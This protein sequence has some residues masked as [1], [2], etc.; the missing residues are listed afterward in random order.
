MTH[1]V[2]SRFDWTSAHF[3]YPEQTRFYH[4]LINGPRFIKLFRPNPTL[5]SDGTWKP[6]SPDD[7]EIALCLPQEAEERFKEIMRQEVRNLGAVG[8]IEFVV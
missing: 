2:P 1:Y 4:T 5:L 8:C 7:V 6:S 3:G